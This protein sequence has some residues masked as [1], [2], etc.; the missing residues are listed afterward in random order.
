MLEPTR[1]RVPGALWK[2]AHI[3]GVRFAGMFLGM[4]F[5]LVRHPVYEGFYGGRALE[6]GLTPLEDQ[7]IAG[8]L[9]LG[10]DLVVMIGALT[11]FFLRTAPGRRPR[12]GSGR[13]AEAGRSGAPSNFGGGGL[14]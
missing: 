14:G 13:A 6:H 7:Q 4:A 11:F 5:L 2:I 9:M 12:G 3:T 1:R 10:L 8:G